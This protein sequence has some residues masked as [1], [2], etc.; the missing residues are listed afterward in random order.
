MPS[1]VVVAITQRA[2]CGGKPFVWIQSLELTHSVA[3]IQLVVN[4]GS[5]DSLRGTIL[6][7]V[8]EITIKEHSLAAAVAKITV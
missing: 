4:L 2:C 3:D 8:F 5:L 6:V 7:L 1:R